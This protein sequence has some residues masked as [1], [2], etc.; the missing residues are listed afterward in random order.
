MAEI[1]GRN[2]AD[3]RKAAGMHQYQ[4][5]HQM[6]VSEDVIGAWEREE[7]DPHPD[8]VDAL[9]KLYKTPLW[10][11]W[12]R[13]HFKSYRDRYPETAQDHSLALALIN[14]RHQMQ[15]VVSL[16][17]QVER[18][19]LDGKIDNRALAQRYV[20]EMSETV[21]ALQTM[22]ELLQQGGGTNG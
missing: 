1:T 18:D 6:H 5:A 4:V 16:Q 15:D 14:A 17:D 3:A 13:Y 9:E 19:A 10:H 2:L 11:G 7:R 20:K 12:M 8:Q 22:I 21:V